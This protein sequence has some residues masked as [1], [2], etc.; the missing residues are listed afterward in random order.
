MSSPF[1]SRRKS[2]HIEVAASGAENIRQMVADAPGRDREQ[3]DAHRF[4]QFVALDA[5]PQFAK[6][7]QM[8]RRQQIKETDFPSVPQGELKK[9]SAAKH[10]VA[11]S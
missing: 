7:Q 1:I 8:L 10:P 6:A 3:F 11:A 4:G 5:A 9:E 2:D